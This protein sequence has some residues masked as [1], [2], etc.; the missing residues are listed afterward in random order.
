MRE[1]SPVGVQLHRRDREGDGYKTE[2]RRAVLDKTEGALPHQEPNHDRDRKCP[3]PEADSTQDL[4]RKPNSAQLRDQDEEGHGD[5]AEHHDREEWKSK[6]F[7]GGIDNGVLAHRR[8]AA[9]HLD[10]KDQADRSEQNR[11]QKLVAVVRARLRGGDNRPDLE[12]SSDAGNDAEGQLENLFHCFDSA[13]SANC[14][15]SV[16]SAISE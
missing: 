10:E 5:N 6:S 16:S 9:R 4:E 11:P 13:L 12:E 8:Q 2:Q 14:F 7:A 1:I 3:P 15:T